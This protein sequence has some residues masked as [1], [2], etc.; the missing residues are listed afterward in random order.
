ML[1][2]RRHIPRCDHTQ[3]ASG[4][5]S[6]TSGIPSYG[7]VPSNTTTAGRSRFTASDTRSVKMSF[8]RR[9][10]NPVAPADGRYSNENPY[11]VTT[12]TAWERERKCGAMFGSARRAYAIRR[13]KCPI[14]D[15]L[16]L[17]RSSA[18]RS[19]LERLGKEALDL[20]CLTI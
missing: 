17:I 9:G 3:R 13:V 16:L 11:W 12:Q 5:S 4:Y 2:P 15:P 1:M 18:G 6:R 19:E 7:R 10:D 14:P 20:C 8:Q